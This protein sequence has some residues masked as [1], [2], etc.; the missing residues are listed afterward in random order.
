MEMTIPSLNGYTNT[1]ANVGK[2]SNIGIDLTLNTVNVK[3]RSFEWSTSINA[4]WQKD[5]IDE[6]ANGKEDDIKKKMLPRWLSSM[7][8][9]IRSKQVWHVQ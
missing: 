8:R 3:T 6:L 9:D 2:T 7:L 1:Y 4:A 5:K